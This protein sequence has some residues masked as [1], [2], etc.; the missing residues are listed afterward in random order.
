MEVEKGVEE[1]KGAGEV[2][3]GGEEGDKG[4][5]KRHGGMRGTRRWNGD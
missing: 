4:V 2:G 5:G 3:R 1:Y